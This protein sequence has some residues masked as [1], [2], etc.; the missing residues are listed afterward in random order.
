GADRECLRTLEEPEPEQFREA[1][2]VTD[3][4]AHGQ[5]GPCAA[6][7]FIARLPPIG[8]NVASAL[9]SFR[10]ASVGEWMDFRVIDGHV[11]RWADNGGPVLRVRAMARVNGACPLDVDTEVLGELHEIFQRGAITV[12]GGFEVEGK[13]GIEHLW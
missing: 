2:V 10:L 9:E 7:V 4:G 12:R 1:Q 5:P 6:P 3:G 11:A 8:N 13:T